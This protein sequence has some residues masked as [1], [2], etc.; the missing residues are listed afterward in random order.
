MDGLSF[1]SQSCGQA[2]E[3]SDGLFEGRGLLIVLLL[4]AISRGED[5]GECRRV[6]VGQKGGPP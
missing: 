5:G 6:D 1:P 3:H 4:G 2:E